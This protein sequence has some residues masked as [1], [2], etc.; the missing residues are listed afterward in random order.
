MSD[1]PSPETIEEGDE[2][3]HVRYRDPDDFETIRTPDWADDVSDSVVEDSEVRMGQ[4]EDSDEWEPQ[5]VLVP[6]ETDEATAREQADEILRKI[7]N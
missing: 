6:K 7:E 2:Y 5:A 3:V 1:I 4:L